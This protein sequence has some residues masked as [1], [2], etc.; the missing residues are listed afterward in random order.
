MIGAVQGMNRYPSNDKHVVFQDVLCVR[1]GVSADG[2]EWNGVLACHQ[3]RHHGA[4]LRHFSLV[5]A[6][7]T[8]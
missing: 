2:R 8:V 1:C 6:E 3:G 5:Y 7:T 4:I